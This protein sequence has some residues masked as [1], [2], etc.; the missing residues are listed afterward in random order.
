MSG[1][2]LR[3]Y[4]RAIN[5]RLQLRSARDGLS[6]Y[7]DGIYCGPGWGFTIDDVKSGRIREMPEAFDAIDGACR[8]HDQCFM[9][10]GYFSLSCDLALNRRLTQVVF[11]LDSTPGQR[12]DAV[13]MAAYFVVQTALIDLPVS[14]Y[15]VVRDRIEVAFLQGALMIDIIERELISSP[16]RFFH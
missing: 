10:H 2:I 15:R 11:A 4:L 5:S 1:M 6:V 16:I 9:D 13:I 7:R 12:F 3:G 8:L 14:S